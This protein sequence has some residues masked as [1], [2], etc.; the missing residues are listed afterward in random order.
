MVFKNR[1]DQ[2]SGGIEE[3]KRDRLTGEPPRQNTMNREQAETLLAKM[4]FDE[5]DPTE[6]AE[7]EAYLQTD[8]ELRERLGDMRLTVNL[9]REGGR[10][11]Q[12]ALS[13][14][15]REEL[16]RQTR[17]S[18]Y[19]QEEEQT[20]G[21]RTL[22]SY[23]IPVLGSIAAVI[24]IGFLL[25]ILMPALNQDRRYVTVESVEV[26]E[27]SVS[28]DT[29]MAGQSLVVS[30]T[31]SY[32]PDAM[33]DGL[34]E[35]DGDAV[36]ESLLTRF[37]ALDTESEVD[38][39]KW[40]SLT[41][42]RNE[43]EARF[44]NGSVDWLDTRLGASRSAGQAR[45]FY[46][47]DTDHPVMAGEQL[48]FGAQPATRDGADQVVVPQLG[49]LTTDYDSFA[50]GDLYGLSTDKPDSDAMSLSSGQSD[51]RRGGEDANVMRS[52]RYHDQ[53]G[54]ADN[55]KEH[56]PQVIVL[57]VPLEVAKTRTAD[58]NGEVEF[59][60]TD[61]AW[62]FNASASGQP[63]SGE[64]GASDLA[65]GTVM[66]YDI[67]GAT[68]NQ[69]RPPIAAY[70]KAQA[71]NEPVD[72]FWTGGQAD[73]RYVELESYVDMDFGLSEQAVPE[74]DLLSRE[75]EFR[76]RDTLGLADSLSAADITQVHTGHVAAAMDISAGSER[77]SKV[78]GQSTDRVRRGPS[79]LS[80]QD[81]KRVTLSDGEGVARDSGL[82][83]R[84][85]T[86]LSVLEGMESRQQTV[87]EL[88][89]EQYAG[90]LL[91]RSDPVAQPAPSEEA[92][93]GSV[94]LAQVEQRIESVERELGR[95]TESLSKFELAGKLTAA[96]RHSVTDASAE[97]PLPPASRFAEVPV[98]PWE[99]SIRDN[100]ST[101]A[102]DTD[103]A[104]YRQCAR[105]IRGGYLPPRGA[106]RMEAF[107]NA[108][109]YN[110]TKSSEQA[111]T[112][113][114]DAAPNPFA[115]P[116]ND[117]VLVKVG[118]QGRVIGREGRKPAHLVFVV[119]AS[120]SMAQPERLPLA[121]TSLNGLVMNLSP[122][123]RVS[124]VT[125]GVA[126]EVQLEAEAASNQTQ[127][128]DRI[129][130][131]QTTG[132][133]NLTDGLEAGYQLAARHY[134]ADRINRV[135]MVSDGMAN[136]GRTEATEVVDRVADYRRQG[137]TFTAVGVGAGGYNDELL[138]TLAHNG[139]GNYLYFDNAA[140][141]K[142]QF[143]D[144]MDANLQTIAK[145]AKIQVVFNTQRVRR[146]RLIGYEN[147]AIAD[148]DFR[149]DAIDAGEVGSGQSSTAL[150]EVEL[151]PASGRAS[152]QP[153]LATVY[154]RYRDADTNRVEEVSRVIESGAVC[155]TPVSERPRFYL[156]A[157]VA[158]FAEVLRESPH[159]QDGN[160]AEV[161]RVVEEVHRELPL[162]D[163]VA[164]LRDLVR[165]AEGLDRAP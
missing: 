88:S 74:I 1:T 44:D 77:K 21:R 155:E 118:V 164:E 130:R 117:T 72:V 132:S 152:E 141:A 144:N 52:Y 98:N 131:I 41:R 160:F 23:R 31:E 127:I 10:G 103:T 80:P 26:T 148:K 83:G 67:N 109:D 18:V 90:A 136:V 32:E 122:E 138:E 48:A 158:R 106:V 3:N 19:R 96:Q 112:I 82:A 39:K 59:V 81:N 91:V 46:G 58:Q 137:V 84:E 99:L 113:H 12:S 124:L 4:I 147:R 5:L 161:L 64:E 68:E 156:A 27:W 15:R 163:R 133:T 149:N 50:S 49:D 151:Y 97:S 2:A 7:L 25:T 13:D 159:A 51:G 108:F 42:N 40:R 95:R 20:Q 30:P 129:N 29:E 135:I 66:L 37:Y 71:K 87:E 54:H 105:Y 146:Y 153:P 89:Q 142:R 60:E 102:L 65:S 94:K 45:D 165:K 93:G 111:F 116:G 78:P 92:K 14:D 17:M 6:Y 11:D 104:S 79:P 85:R 120:G 110:Y 63:A 22:A 36:H 75:I 86:E 62:S 140:E 43:G 69:S 150:Y 128:I 126:A 35:V 145:D 53:A 134:T 139:D 24:L 123:D 162:D 16:L 114:A 100:Q 101:F 47:L 143:V 157:A 34:G 119:D 57:G 56:E 125:Y 76:T 121:Q 55:L 9:I 107:V 28:A 8:P 70:A 154:V 115:S 33:R 38:D 73:V 61:A